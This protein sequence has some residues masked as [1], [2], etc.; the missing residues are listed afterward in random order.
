MPSKQRKIF[1]LA[2]EGKRNSEIAEILETNINTVKALK[3]RGIA[4]LR[5]TL[6]PDALLLLALLLE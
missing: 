4:R 2:I 3:R 1:L 6:Q 5:A